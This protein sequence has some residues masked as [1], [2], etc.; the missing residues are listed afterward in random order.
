MVNAV[1]SGTQ[2]R[3]RVLQLNLSSTARCAYDPANNLQGLRIRRVHPVTRA[4]STRS[5]LASQLKL[6][7]N[8]FRLREH[9]VAATRTQ[10]VL[11]ISRAFPMHDT[12]ESICPFLLGP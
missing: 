1:R 6:L 9:H 8:S 12:L 10:G 7:S 3:P 2:Q 11:P 4:D 5:Y